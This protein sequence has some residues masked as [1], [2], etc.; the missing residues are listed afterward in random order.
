MLPRESF[1]QENATTYAKAAIDW[2]QFAGQTISLAGAVHPWSNTITPL[3]RDFTKLTGIEVTTD[4][5]LETTFLGALPIKLARGSSTP[6]VFMF[7]T[8]GQGITAGWLEPL[9]AH[10]SDPSLPHLASYDR[11]ALL[12]T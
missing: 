3:L 10:Y 4:F 12:T 6:D 1:A 2:K 8:Y 7:L 11:T 5:Q 9:N